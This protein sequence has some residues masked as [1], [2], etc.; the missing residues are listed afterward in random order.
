MSMYNVP[1]CTCGVDQW[2]PAGRR[3]EL[4]KEE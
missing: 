1:V 3:V 2:Q 4:G